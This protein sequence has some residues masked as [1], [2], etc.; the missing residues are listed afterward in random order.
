MDSPRISVVMAAYNEEALIQRAI[1]SLLAQTFGDFELLVIDDGS[2]DRTVEIV[3]RYTDDRIRLF[4]PGRLG[5]TKA[6]NFGL[7]NA[8]GELIARLDADDEDLPD[9][10]K[11][12]V[13]FLDTHPE[14]SILGTA[15]IKHDAMRHEDFIRHFPEKDC[16]IKK[17]MSF[18]IP[19]CHGSVMFRKQVIDR[20][21]GY[22]ENIPDAED[23]ELWIRA[24]SAGFMFHN[25]QVP[26][27]VYWFDSKTSYFEATLGRRKRALNTLKLNA[28]AIKQMHLPVYYYLL[29]GAK[30]V[31]Y[32]LLPTRLKTVARK[33]VSRS[34]E[35][36]L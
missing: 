8:R 32:F 20:I 12:Q 24:A 29:L 18:Q 34:T 6:L 1:N 7:K 21:G 19:I 11:S 5:F 9:R 3:Q 10:F 31:Y 23:L 22:N 28:R 4:T 13:E 33:L 26:L 17:T 27:H 35:V 14:I 16:D 15:Y 36:R 25:L 30:L 2:K